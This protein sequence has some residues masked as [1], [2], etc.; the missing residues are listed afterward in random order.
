MAMGQNVRSMW[1][2]QKPEVGS[3]GMGFGLGGTPSTWVKGME[4][5]AKILRRLLSDKRHMWTRNRDPKERESR[6]V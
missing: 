2:E 6:F 5:K 1:R 3:P 4:K